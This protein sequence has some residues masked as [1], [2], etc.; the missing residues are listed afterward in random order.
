VPVIQAGEH[1]G[2]MPG[3]LNQ[4]GIIYAFACWRSHIGSV[5]LVWVACEE[6]DIGHQLSPVRLIQVHVRSSAAGNELT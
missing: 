5:P 2:L 4:R 1:L 6:H 3:L